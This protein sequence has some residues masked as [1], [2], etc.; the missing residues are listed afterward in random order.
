MLNKILI[1]ALAAVAYFTGYL[2]GTNDVIAQWKE[3]TADLQ[4]TALNQANSIIDLNK[5]L[6]E[7]KDEAENELVAQEA[8]QKNTVNQLN[9]LLVSMR[10]R[11]RDSNDSSS[12]N[13]VPNSPIIKSTDET[14]SCNR[15]KVTLDRC[16]A[17]SGQLA[18]ERDEIGL[19]L[20]TL[21]DFYESTRSKVN[22]QPQ[23][24]DTTNP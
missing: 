7:Q 23:R 15:W 8:Q 5:Q 1:I 6:E 3:Q 2:A 13:A 18:T 14:K 24:L 4:Q 16:L 12:T 10:D 17:I 21:I 19:R 22:E 11:L 20:N 9:T